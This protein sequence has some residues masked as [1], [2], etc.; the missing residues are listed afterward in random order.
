MMPG[1]GKWVTVQL[2]T[3]FTGNFKLNAALAAILAQWA[4]GAGG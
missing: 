3:L 4:R 1:P 2:V